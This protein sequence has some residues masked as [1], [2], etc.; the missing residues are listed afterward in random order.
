MIRTVL[1]LVFGVGVGGWGEEEVQKKKNDRRRRRRRR[2]RRSSA[3][4]VSWN[5]RPV[6]AR[7]SNW[8]TVP[9]NWAAGPL[10]SAP[11]RRRSCPATVP[12]P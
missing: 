4:S 7:P 8:G 3:G 10:L 11:R 1:L 5:R 6:A 9:S 2:R 12:W